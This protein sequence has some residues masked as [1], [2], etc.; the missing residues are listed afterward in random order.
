MLCTKCKADRAHRSHRR[1][2]L[3]LAASFFGYYPYRCGDCGHRFLQFRYS[4]A[5]NTV[6][7]KSST[8]R[9]IRATRTALR[10]RQKRRDFLLY[11]SGVL[12]FLVFLYFITRER[13]TS[14]GN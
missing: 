2:V 3:E 14:D 4:E 9:E 11:G 13:G 7:A 12:L 5:L 6:P 1:G 10:W 8:E